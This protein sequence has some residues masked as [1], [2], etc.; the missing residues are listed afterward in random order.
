MDGQRFDDRSGTLAAA[1]SCHEALR[2][3]VGGVWMVTVESAG[4]MPLSVQAIIRSLTSNGG[5]ANSAAP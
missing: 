1:T 5:V 4:H 2:L 3:V